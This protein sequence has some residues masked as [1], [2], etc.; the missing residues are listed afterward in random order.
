MHRAILDG[1]DPY[2]AQAK[3]ARL[4]FIR[5]GSGRLDPR[6]MLGLEEAF[7]APVLERYGM[8]ETCTLTYNP[9]PPAVRRPGTVGIVGTNSVRIVDHA[10]TVLGPN[11]EGEIVARGPSVVDRYWD[12]PQATSTAFIDGWFHTGDLGRFDEDGY[13]TITGR[14]KDLI[15]RG[16][17]KS[18][19]PRSRTSCSNIRR[20]PK[21]ACFRSL[22]RR[23]VKRLPSLW[24][25]GR[26]AF[27][28]K[29]G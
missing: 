13:L 8:S 3:A 19:L 29:Q 2:R 15:N 5:S 1:I 14:I 28:T 24:C 7:G 21:R 26:R 25:S 6:V 12:D 9:P 27:S 18:R 20:S 23:L 17:E 16:G 11:Q 4:R 22:I 10:G